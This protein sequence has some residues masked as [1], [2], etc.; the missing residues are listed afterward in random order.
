MPLFQSRAFNQ[1]KA[2]AYTHSSLFSYDSLMKCVPHRWQHTRK[3]ALQ[4]DVHLTNNIHTN[5][6]KFTSNT[7]TWWRTPV[8]NTSLCDSSLS[9][10]NSAGIDM[11]KLLIVVM[12]SALIKRQ[13]CHRELMRAREWAKVCVRF[14][15]GKKLF[16]H[17][18]SAPEHTHFTPL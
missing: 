5:T 1:T 14:S 6:N 11:G 4:Y 15:S 16:V 2:E 7:R 3:L 12:F 13:K 17:S 18:V 9:L 10:V 8:R